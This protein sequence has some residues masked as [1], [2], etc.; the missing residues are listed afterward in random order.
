[1]ELYQLMILTINF[2]NMFIFKERQISRFFYVYKLIIIYSVCMVV[3]GY[4][5]NLLRFAQQIYP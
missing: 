3:K 4:K 2:N 5:D 1:M